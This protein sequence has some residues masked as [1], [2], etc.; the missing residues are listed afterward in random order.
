MKI[1]SKVLSISPYISTTWENIISMHQKEN[2]LVIILKEGP[3][4]EIPQLTGDAIELIFNAHA[5]YV[6]ESQLPAPQKESFS[7]SFPTKESGDLLEAFGTTAQ[8]NPE[9]S[10]LPSLPPGLLKKIGTIAEVFGADALSGLPKAEPGCNCIYCQVVNAMQKETVVEEEITEEDLKFRSWDVNQT[11][12]QLYTVTSP[13]DM[14]EHY[15]VYLGDPIGCTC[16]Q[17]NCEHIRA[18][19]NT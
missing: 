15:S 10:N 1:T 7:L 18:V 2:G 14:N 16:G 8:H 4:V 6:S 19:L 11:A 3:Q 12:D 13:L 17:K 5:R 9:Q